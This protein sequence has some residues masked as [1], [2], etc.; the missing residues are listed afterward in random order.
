MRI[1][2]LVMALVFA[3]CTSTGDATTTSRGSGEEP[4]T[5]TT[6]GGSASVPAAETQRPTLTVVGEG[7]GYGVPDRM[8]ATLVVSVLRPE[9]A[10]AAS[11][12]AQVGLNVTN[13]L[14]RAGVTAKDIQSSDYTVM[15]HYRWD[16]AASN[17]DGF[18]VRH[19]YLVKMP[20][21][22]A[23]RAIDA[24][25]ADSWDALE[26]QYT[27]LYVEDEAELQAVAR[28]EAWAD[29]EETAKQ[30]AENAGMKLGRLVSITEGYENTYLGPELGADGEGDGGTSFEPGRIAIQ[31]TIEAVFVLEAA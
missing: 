3:S 17:F 4:A 6:A 11:V 9:V 7:L 16:G 28:V 1:L 2:A 23:G 24:A 22:I 21:E 25:Y 12:A 10:E 29:C 5:T 31:A 20:F 15:S 13:A 14:V 27:R 8:S 18:R 30:L 26:V 19:T